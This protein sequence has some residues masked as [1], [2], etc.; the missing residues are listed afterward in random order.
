MKL[1]HMEQ[2]KTP[3]Y[4]LNMG[5]RLFPLGVLKFLGVKS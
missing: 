2:K 1:E 4:F 3:K 5:N